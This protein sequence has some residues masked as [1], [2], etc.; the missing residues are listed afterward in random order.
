MPHQVDPATFPAITVDV[1]GLGRRHEPAPI[2][3]G[4]LVTL[5]ENLE[6]ENQALLRRDASLL[7]AVDHGDRLAEM[8]GRLKDGDRVRPDGH[9]STTGSTP[10]HVVVIAPFG[11]Q[12]G[13]SLGFESRGT[14][15]DRDLR[16]E[17]RLAGHEDVPIRANVRRPAAD[18]RPLDH[19][20]PT[21]R[22][23]PAADRRRPARRDGGSSDPQGLRRH[24]GPGDP[25]LDLRERG[26]ARRR[27]VVAERREAA[28]VGRAELAGFDE[29]GRLQD[30]VA[31]LLGRLDPRVDRV[32]DADEDPAAAGAL[33]EDL[34]AGSRSVSLAS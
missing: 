25:G 33:A 11:V 3:Q 1:A 27:G 4:I 8:Q 22:G 24:R 28:V 29:P 15:T 18:R 17:R 30:P 7:T 9:R 26:V 13:G 12:T 5:A 31:D 16:R 21:C 6:L 14:V 23:L 32:D 34:S 20:R 19:R 2:A 10:S